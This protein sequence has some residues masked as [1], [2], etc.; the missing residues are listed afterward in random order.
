MTLSVFTAK[1]FLL[2]A[3]GRGG[4]GNLEISINLFAVM[5]L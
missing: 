4:Q 5:T 3:A 1:R 2:D